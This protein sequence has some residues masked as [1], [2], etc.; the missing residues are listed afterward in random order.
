MK[1][2]NDRRMGLPP[3]LAACTMTTVHASRGGSARSVSVIRRVNRSPRN[4][5]GKIPPGDLRWPQQTARSERE[6]PVTRVG[7]GQQ[8]KGAH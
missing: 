2:G 5:K 1:G 7:G 4:E 8:S 3:M 6:P